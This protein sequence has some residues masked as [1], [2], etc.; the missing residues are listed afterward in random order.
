MTRASGSSRISFRSESSGRWRGPG[1][2]ENSIRRPGACRVSKLQQARLGLRVTTQPAELA[3]AFERSGKGTQAF[4]SSLAG[5]DVLSNG[6]GVVLLSE[7][8]AP[9]RIDVD[10]KNIEF[11]NVEVDI[12]V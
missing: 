6:S 3:V 7:R 12:V 8:D 9:G 1:L 11:L 10:P 4:G 2:D 5:R